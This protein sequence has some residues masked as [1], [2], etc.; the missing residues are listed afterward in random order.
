MTTKF[1]RIVEGSGEK[2]PRGFPG[3]GIDDI[4]FDEENEEFIV[5]YTNESTTRIPFPEI[6]LSNYVT[7]P[8]LI[9][10]LTN[11]VSN[12]S[13]SSTLSSYI[14][15]SSLSSSLSNYCLKNSPSITSP[16]FLGEMT[17][18]FIPTSNVTY[19]LGSYSKRFNELHT[20]CIQDMGEIVTIRNP[21]SNNG[22]WGKLEIHGTWHGNITNSIEL[23]NNSTSANS[24][25][26]IGFNGRSSLAVVSNGVLG[27]NGSNF[28]VDKNFCPFDTAT[29]SLGNNT[30][31]WKEV[32]ANNIY[33]DN[34][35][36]EFM[37]GTNILLFKGQQFAPKVDEGA[38]LGHI[39]YK[40]FSVIAKNGTIDTSDR[41]LKDN[42][43]DCDLGL[44]FVND[45]QPRKY[46]WNNET[47]NDVR[48]GLIAQELEE[49][50]NDHNCP[51][52]QGL[53]KPKDETETYGLCYSQL[54]PILI[55]SVQELS[56]KI[57]NLEH[58]ISTNNI[59]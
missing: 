20:N 16:T 46:N 12:T 52:F 37:D 13:L 35:G 34:T 59:S 55:K 5:Y 26:R 18:D 21:S 57:K 43:I 53:Q 4:I 32:Y 22:K 38:S 24:G 51:N 54:I 7:N 58:I 15:S 10:T 45:L 56:E 28:Y 1:G 8:S 31:R 39:S 40:W 23:Y 36:F 41:R 19:H 9:T 25:A 14:T 49:T 3:V 33:F 17:G 29:T 11:Y 50:L 44:D 48:Y 6:T 42:I 47:I 2:G 27:F 30:K